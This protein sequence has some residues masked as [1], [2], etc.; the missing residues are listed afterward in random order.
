MS[1]TA[2][3]I[4][5]DI[6]TCSF[7][8]AATSPVQLARMGVEAFLV[9]TDVAAVVGYAREAAVSPHDRI[10]LAN[11]FAFAFELRGGCFPPAMFRTK[12]ATVSQHP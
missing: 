6:R 3:A 10:H 12:L 7:T 9:K 5:P 8:V 1:L 11:Q 2:S 4:L